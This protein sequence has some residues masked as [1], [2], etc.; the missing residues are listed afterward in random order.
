[1]LYSVASLYHAIINCTSA[2][3]Q[4]I[5]TVRNFANRLK[6]ICDVTTLYASLNS[7]TTLTPGEKIQGGARFPCPL[8][9]LPRLYNYEWFFKTLSLPG[10]SFTK[11]LVLPF[12]TVSRLGVKWLI[13]PAADSNACNS[14]SIYPFCSKL[15]NLSANLSF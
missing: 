6:L 15:S 8:L 11:F 4:L 2:S 10:L 3:V 5:K 7:Q 1:M 9:Y 12:L 13:G 14:G